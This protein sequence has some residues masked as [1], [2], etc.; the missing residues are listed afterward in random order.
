MGVS[1]HLSLAMPGNQN[2]QVTLES[3]APLLQPPS[4]LGVGAL[5]L[6]CSQAVV[7]IHTVLSHPLWGSQKPG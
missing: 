6:S 1:G 5:S 2:L 7:L 4:L 3:S